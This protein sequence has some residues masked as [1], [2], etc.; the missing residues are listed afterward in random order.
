MN[1]DFASTRRRGIWSPVA[2]DVKSRRV[3]IRSESDCEA[4]SVR[5]FK[6]DSHAGS[7][8]ADGIAF[9]TQRDAHHVSRPGK[10]FMQ[11]FVQARTDHNHILGIRGC[12]QFFADSQCTCAEEFP[13]LVATKNEKGHQCHEPHCDKRGDDL[14]FVHVVARWLTLLRRAFA[15]KR[16]FVLKG[17]HD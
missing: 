13:A 4:F 1:T 17:R 9:V 12:N 7:A 8:I 3:G 16:D 5:V 6:E 14:L 15:L 10:K 2:N 11:S